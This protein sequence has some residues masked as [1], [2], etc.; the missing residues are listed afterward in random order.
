MNEFEADLT[1][2]SIN[3]IV[4]RG[5]AQYEIEFNNREFRVRVENVNL[6]AGTVLN[7]LV[8]GAQVG[9][10]SVAPSLDRSEF[11]LKTEDGQAVPQINSRTRVVVASAAGATLLAGSFSNIPQ[12]LGN[13][14][15]APMPTPGPGGEL[16]ID[17]RLAGA[18]INGLTPTGVAKFRDRAGNRN[19]EVE[20]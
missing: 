19:F 1:G 5:D 6:P 11:R 4:P 3:G 12:V 10:L 2:A 20:V 9:T 17:A 16:R 13:P 14:G 15:P 18:A 7:V 8:D